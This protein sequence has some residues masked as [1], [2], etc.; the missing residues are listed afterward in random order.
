MTL[1]RVLCLTLAALTIGRAASPENS[2][3]LSQL[4]A[5]SFAKAHT[6]SI[7]KLTTPS[8]GYKPDFH[9]CV[10]ASDWKPLDGKPRDELVALLQQ[11]INEQINVITHDLEGHYG[12]LEPFG[13]V[14]GDYGI[15]IKTDQGTREFSITLPK[16]GGSGFLY[17]Y[18]AAKKS[19]GLVSDQELTQKFAAYQPH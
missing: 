1:L 18:A 8:T 4:Q 13:N 10:L 12:F 3:R 19:L 9:G 5:L 11:I 15:R 2:E 17:G 16:N 14:Y 7:A 6:V